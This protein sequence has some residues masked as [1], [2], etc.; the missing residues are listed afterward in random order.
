M[1]RPSP[2]KRWL[3]GG[4]SPERRRVQERPPFAV[5]GVYQMRCLDQMR[6]LIPPITLP[7]PN[8]YPSKEETQL[9]MS[10]GVPKADGHRPCMAL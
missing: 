3:L 5:R 10:N 1:R 7:G 6:Q 4:R 2:Q 8:Y 9:A